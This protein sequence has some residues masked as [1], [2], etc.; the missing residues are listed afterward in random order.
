[1]EVDE[2]IILHTT[3]VHKTRAIHIN[4]S[5]LHHMTSISRALP[6]DLPHTQQCWMKCGKPWKSNLVENDQSKGL[7]LET[8]R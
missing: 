7:L 6:K 2:I 4:T 1:M 8:D 3:L 5:C